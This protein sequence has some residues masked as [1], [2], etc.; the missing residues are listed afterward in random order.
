MPEKIP[1][2]LI[3]TFCAIGGLIDVGTEE[4]KSKKRVGEKKIRTMKEGERIENIYRK[5]RRKKRKKKRKKLTATIP[6][7]FSIST[8]NDLMS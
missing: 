6:R 5:K 4:K 8:H 7:R 3:A 2:M 1:T